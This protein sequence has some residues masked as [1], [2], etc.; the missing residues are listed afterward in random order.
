MSKAQQK[1]FD[2]YGFTYAAQLWGESDSHPVIAL[3]GWLDNSASFEVLAPL[4]D[5]SQIQVLAIDLAGHGLSQHRS[6]ISDYPI[7]SEIASIYAIADEMGWSEFSLMGH[8]RGA[9]ISLLMAGTYPQRITQLIMIDA[10]LPPIVPAEDAQARMVNSLNEL[11][12]RLKRVSLYDTYDDAIFA[13]A[14]SRFGNIQTST[15]ERLAAR[16]LHKVGQQYQW[17]AD[18]KLW[19]LSNIGLSLA[20][21]QSFVDKITAPSH[22]L[23]G[24]QGL[25]QGNSEQSKYLVAFEQVVSALSI[26]IHEFDDGH[27]LHMEK[28]AHRVAETINSFLLDR[29]TS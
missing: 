25:M 26:N 29:I 11:H 10:L 28:S 19:A 18:G 13:R 9:M 5:L 24:R 14:N 17:H 6:G 22:L 15:A 4:L 27:F 20:M 2:L 1:R 16:G 23:L 3:H 7:W 8:S 21:V 12:R